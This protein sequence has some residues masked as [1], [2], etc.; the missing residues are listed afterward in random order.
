MLFT[1]GF[2][3]TPQKQ[4]P[5]WEL[6]LL[7]LKGDRK[8]D[9]SPRLCD[10]NSRILELYQ[11]RKKDSFFLLVEF[12]Q[13]GTCISLQD[14]LL[15]ILFNIFLHLVPSN[16]KRKMKKETNQPID[17]LCSLFFSCQNEKK[18]NEEEEILGTL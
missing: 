14:S 7:L 17:R 9:S 13:I 18:E 16:K 5:H 8:W 6:L 4:D 3:P 12:I 2:S 11:V 15:L 1:S 10:E